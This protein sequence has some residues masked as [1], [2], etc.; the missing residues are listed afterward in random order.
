MEIRNK[1]KTL[2]TANFKSSNLL[3]KV[4][5]I[6]PQAAQ[7]YT[8]LYCEHCQTVLIPP[9]LKTHEKVL[10]GAPTNA[11]LIAMWEDL[12]MKPTMLDYAG[13]FLPLKDDII[14][15]PN[16]RRF[17]VRP[18]DHPWYTHRYTVEEVPKKENATIAKAAKAASSQ[19]APKKMTLKRPAPASQVSSNSKQVTL[20]GKH[21]KQMHFKSISSMLNSDLDLKGRCEDDMDVFAKGYCLSMVHLGTKKMISNAAICEMYTT[22]VEGRFKFVN[23][24]HP[25]SSY[26]TSSQQ[27]I[28]RLK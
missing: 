11:N 7:Q 19:S 22:A 8:R 6:G 3:V 23:Y 14:A 27:G 10:G 26:A 16:A 12:K 28:K 13:S 2:T 20:G 4:K 21:G 18:R 5:H 9:I 24:G 1:F 25:N 15:G 17:I